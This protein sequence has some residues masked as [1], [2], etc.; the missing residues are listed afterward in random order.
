M[1]TY[2][3]DL[4]WSAEDLRTNLQHYKIYYAV[5]FCFLRDLLYNFEGGE[6]GSTQMEVVEGPSSPSKS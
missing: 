3:T 2:L 6:R 4:T 5:S 1:Q